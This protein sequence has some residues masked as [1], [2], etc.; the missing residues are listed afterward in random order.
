M[1]EV[2]WRISHEPEEKTI[3]YQGKDF[4]IQVRPMTWSKRNQ[5]VSQCLTYTER[6]EAQFNLDRYYKE[7]IMYMIPQGPWGKTDAIFLTSINEELGRILQ[8]FVSNPFD[9]GGVEA[10]DFFDEEREQSS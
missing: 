8:S 9:S 4:T 10:Q 5:I 2:Q 6:G 3:H 7:S 1:A